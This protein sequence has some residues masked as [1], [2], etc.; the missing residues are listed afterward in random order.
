MFPAGAVR[1]LEVV[2]VVVNRHQEFVRVAVLLRDVC[3][4]AALPPPEFRA[5]RGA[6]RKREE[7]E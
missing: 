4:H 5:R 2:D 6:R 3:A 7:E 1:P